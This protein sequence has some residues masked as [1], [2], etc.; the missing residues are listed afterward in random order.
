[1]IIFCPSIPRKTGQVS[2]ATNETVFLFLVAFTI[3]SVGVYDS[4]DSSG[5]DQSRPNSMS[6]LRR[7]GQSR[8]PLRQPGQTKDQ[9][10]IGMGQGKVWQIPPIQKEG[11]RCGWRADSGKIGGHEGTNPCRLDHGN[12]IK[13]T[14]G[15]SI[16]SKRIGSTSVHQLQPIYFGW[17]ENVHSDQ[18][19]EPDYFGHSRQR[20]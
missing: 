14:G 17:T 6:P 19:K 4:D 12:G 7:C 5:G 1:M 2:W 16:S 8:W 10:Q 18:W 13:G 15:M 20:R 11:S 3:L 9:R